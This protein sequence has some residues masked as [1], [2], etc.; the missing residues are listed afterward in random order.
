MTGPLSDELLDELH[1]L[2]EVLDETSSSTDMN[3]VGEYWASTYQD[4][5]GSWNDAL[6]QLPTTE[7][8]GLSVDFPSAVA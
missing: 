2:S 8:V 6:R 4:Q 3:E 5:F 1:R 7:V